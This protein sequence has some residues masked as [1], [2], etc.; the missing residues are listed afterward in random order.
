MVHT[1]TLTYITEQSDGLYNSFIGLDSTHKNQRLEKYYN[2]SLKENGITL[3][4]YK[5]PRPGRTL[6]ILMMRINFKR[7]IEQQDRVAVMT[8]LETD[9]I[10]NRCNE[11][12][13]GLMGEL[14]AFH[15]WKVNRI[16]YCINVHT[17]Y[18]SKYIKLLQKSRIP[19]RMK[20]PV[21]A[22]RNRNPRRGSCYLISEKCDKRTGY[23]GSYTINFYDK[24]EEL[25]YQQ[26]KNG[27]SLITDELIEQGRGILRLEIQCHKPKTEYIK[28]KMGFETKSVLNYLNW[29]IGYDL[30]GTA[31]TRVCGTS[32]FHKVSKAKELIDELNCTSKKREK[33]KRL[34][35]II[36]N[37]TLENIKEK[38][39]TE[40]GITET[41][42]KEYIKLLDNHNINVITISD[43]VNLQGEN[44]LASVWSLFHDAFVRELEDDNDSI[45]IDDDLDMA[46]LE[47]DEV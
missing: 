6:Y 41:T 17:P 13:A 28:R 10:E 29:E 20:I 18:V 31:I 16:D 42:F 24:Y 15:E 47:D 34:I 3:W 14:P 39:M 44:K 45:L 40:Q 27:N 1:A 12:L 33:L 9:V 36:S 46:L 30:I 37:S 32:D 26:L 8:E 38:Y 5:L 35:G 2:V 22:Q 21:N 11:L 7:V 25:K 4:A 43:K 19:A 23:K